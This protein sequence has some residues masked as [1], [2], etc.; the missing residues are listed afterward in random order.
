MKFPFTKMARLLYLITLGATGSAGAQAPSSAA[1]LTYR[2]ISQ[3]L[4]MDFPDKTFRV[5]DLRADGTYVDRMELSQF[6]NFEQFSY[7]PLVNGTY[8]Y[9]VLSATQAAL[10]LSSAG[11]SPQT[12]IL[13]FA[14]PADGTLGAIVPGIGPVMEYGV[15]SVSP[16]VAVGASAGLRNVSTLISLTPGNSTTVGFIVG[17]TQLK[18]YVIRC[19]GPT[20]AN[21]GVPNCAA[22]PTYTLDLPLLNGG[23]GASSEQLQLPGEQPILDEPRPAVGWSA[24]PAAAATIGGESARGGAFPL[25]TGSNDKADVILLSP[26]PYTLSVTPSTAAEA[27]TQLIEVYEVP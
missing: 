13:T 11:Y 15:F 18:E 2:S 12:H 16:T 24:T 19:I 6:L 8:A 1:G 4:S 26:G 27:G 5:V 7:Q 25:G 10:T 3:V 23:V 21:F 9:A 22:D 14:E 20:L 17:G